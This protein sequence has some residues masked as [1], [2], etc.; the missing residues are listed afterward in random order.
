VLG[1]EV[2][3]GEKK[4]TTL[5]LGQRIKNKKIPPQDAEDGKASEKKSGQAERKIPP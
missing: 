3:L 4:S 1:E 5:T 2:Q